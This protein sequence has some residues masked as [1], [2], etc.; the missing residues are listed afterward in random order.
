M[1]FGDFHYNFCPYIYEYTLLVRVYS[2]YTLVYSFFSNFIRTAIFIKSK[3]FTN[4]TFLFD[5]PVRGKVILYFN[6]N[7]QC[8]NY[9][10]IILSIQHADGVTNHLFCFLSALSHTSLIRRYVHMYTYIYAMSTHR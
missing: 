1:A 4:T 5:H 8:T 2:E 3:I 9:V 7:I 10:N 6:C